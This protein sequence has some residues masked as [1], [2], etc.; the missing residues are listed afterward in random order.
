MFSYVRL[1]HRPYAFLLTATAGVLGFTGTAHS[2]DPFQTGPGPSSSWLDTVNEQFAE[3]HVV[4]GAGFQVEPKFEGSEDLEISPV[5]MF[6]ADFGEYV[7]VDPSGVDIKTLDYNGFTVTGH[8]GYDSGRDD[9]DAN[10]LDGLGD[11][12]A[13][14]VLGVNLGYET[15]P[16]AFETSLEKIVGGSDGLTATFGAQYAVDFDRF[17]FSIGPSITWADSNYMESYFGVT[18][19]RSVKSGL[20]SFDADAG[21]KRVDLDASATYMM[22]DHWLIRGEVGLGYLIGD[23]ADSPVSEQ[24]FQPS[25][26]FTIGYRF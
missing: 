8:L 17:T 22:T 6:S 20:S 9:D 1:G 14:A 10:H 3:W 16:F 5:P 13:G 7:S 2:E 4:L 12:G 19:R 21:F 23:A 18:D 25:T 26:M 15:G 24:S 11:I